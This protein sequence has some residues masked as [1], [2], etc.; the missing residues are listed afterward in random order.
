MFRPPRLCLLP[1]PQQ[2]V[3]AGLWLHYYKNKN[4]E[5]YENKKLWVIRKFFYLQKI[6][7][8]SFFILLQNYFVTIIRYQE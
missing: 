7:I 5:K 4:Y 8:K 2:A 6:K 3:P 1:T